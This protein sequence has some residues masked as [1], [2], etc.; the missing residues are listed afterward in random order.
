MIYKVLIFSLFLLLCTACQKDAPSPPRILSLQ[1]NCDTLY[2]NHGVVVTTDFSPIDS[3]LFTMSLSEM[4]S[5]K[6]LINGLPMA[7]SSIDEQFQGT[8]PLDSLFDINNLS[9][10][11]HTITVD[12]YSHTGEYHSSK[13]TQVV[14]LP[15]DQVIPTSNLQLAPQTAVIT[16]Q[17]ILTTDNRILDSITLSYSLP[18]TESASI[19]VANRTVT[20]SGG[21]GKIT[22]PISDFITDISNMNNL[23]IPITFHTNS[24]AIGYTDTLLL[25]LLSHL[26][27]PYDS[28]AWHTRFD[29]NDFNSSYNVCPSANISLAEAWKTTRGAGVS[30]AVI[31]QGFEKNHEEL[32]GKV[33]KTYNAEDNTTDVFTGSSAHGTTCAGIS[34]APLNGVGL[35][36]AAPEANLILIAAPSLSDAALVRAF[37]YAREE[38]A[39]V[40]SCSWGSYNVSQLLSEKIQE[41]Y[42]AGVV[43]VFA[44]GNDN[45]NLDEGNRNDESELPTVL[46]VGSSD[47]KNLLS[48]F[49]NYGSAIDFLAP[50]GSY[51]LGV[52]GTDLMGPSGSHEQMGVVNNNYAFASGT[53][54]SAPLV[55]GV[56]ALMLS[57]NPSLSP[58]EVRTILIE[59]CEKI[60][61]D[62]HYNAN[63]FDT[64]RA[65]GKINAAKAVTL[66]ASYR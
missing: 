58:D 32:L 45:I 34:A 19:T 17:K 24:G 41:L 40:I 53:S 47:E 35:G 30:I 51:T 29:E 10:V 15:R 31:D 6:Y 64:Q 18:S 57:V 54:F 22:L 44:C 59:S 5:Y 23:L 38:G 28:Y 33:T 20:S 7:V 16:N 21:A 3:L 11:S 27:D 36:G 4:G 43:I 56:T 46:G 55:A 60:G 12:L 13:S 65:Y 26:P 61:I 2:Y 14:L 8:L 1:I 66:A 39:G 42:D 63:G 48:S 62:A 9:T 52:L 25:E 50:G 37:D 49:S